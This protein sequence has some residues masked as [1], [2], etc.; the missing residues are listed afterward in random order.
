LTNSCLAA[1]NAH[2]DCISGPTPPTLVECLTNLKLEFIYLDTQNTLNYINNN[3]L[4]NI[5]QLVVPTG[6]YLGVHNCMHALWNVKANSIFVGQARLNNSLGDKNITS[7]PLC[8]TDTIHACTD[9]QNSPAPLVGLSTQSQFVSAVNTIYGPPVDNFFQTPTLSRYYSL[10][11]DNALAIQLVAASPDQNSI[12]FI[13]D[14][15]NTIENNDC[16]EPLPLGRGPFCHKDALWIRI[17]NSNNQVLLNAGI[18]TAQGFTINMAD[19]CV[20]SPLINT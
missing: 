13:F 1:C 12:K 10:T 9:C 7:N 18:D 15:V 2:A 20:P 17:L 16:N 19:I 6:A 14:C 11:I 5:P 4:P 8:S 3:R